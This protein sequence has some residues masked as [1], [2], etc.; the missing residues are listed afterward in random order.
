M[1]GRPLFEK[2][3]NLLKKIYSILKNDDIKL[4]G[5][6]GICSPE[7][8]YSK[9]KSGA[10]LVA[11]YTAMIYHGPFFANEINRLLIKFLQED[12]FENISQAIGIEAE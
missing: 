1:S 10:S 5:V 7:D 3:T 2:S 4:V 8:A 9:I 11:F 12:G 6:G